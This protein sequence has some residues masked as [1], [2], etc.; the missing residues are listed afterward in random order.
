MSQCRVCGNKLPHKH[1][2]C[3]TCKARLCKCG[4]LVSATLPCICEQP[5]NTNSLNQSLS[6]SSANLPSVEGHRASREGVG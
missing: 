6:S 3:P 2:S 1:A 4:R 5:G